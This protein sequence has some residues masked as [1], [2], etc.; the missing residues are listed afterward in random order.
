MQL[1]VTVDTKG[2]MRALEAFPKE[3]SKELRTEMKVQL[4]SIAKDARR[5]HRFNHQ[6]GNLEKS[7]VVKVEMSGT[8]GAIFIDP[9]IS[10]TR[11]KKGVG[12][13]VFIHEGFKTWA[14]DKFLYEAFGRGRIALVAGLTS[15]VNKAIKRVGLA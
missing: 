7:I 5:H 9:D 6:S 13:G 14:P 8:A 1:Q 3:T 4:E 12:Y 15:A 11:T 2:L 10:N